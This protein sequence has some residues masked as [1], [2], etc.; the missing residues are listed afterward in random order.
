[1]GN[2]SVGPGFNYLRK[3]KQKS[4]GKMEDEVYFRWTLKWMEGHTAKWL[5]LEV[6]IRKYNGNIT[7]KVKVR[8]H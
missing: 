8:H 4:R 7:M 3:P 5:R 2:D 6:Q 1:M